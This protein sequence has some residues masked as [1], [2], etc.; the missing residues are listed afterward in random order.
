MA[1]AIAADVRRRG[2][3]R[4]CPHPPRMGCGQRLPLFPDDAGRDVRLCAAPGRLGHDKVMAAAGR[5][6]LRDI[7]DLV[8]IHETILPLG[9]AVW[10]A[11]EKS[12]GFT[13]EGLIAEIRR[14]S[15]YPAS[16]WRALLSS[17]PL[18]PK[19]IMAR[20]RAALDDAEALVARMPTDKQGL[21]F[22]KDGE[23]VQ[24]DPDHLDEYQTHA[25]RRQGQWPTSPEIAAAMFERYNKKPSR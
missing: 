2:D 4:G 12:P 17:E 1:A 7:V 6:E 15:N 23:P 24:P 9:A 11:V 20:L 18:D 22:L 21:L 16:E 19:D 3:A 10:A 8:M 5:R 14:N 25:G 13:P